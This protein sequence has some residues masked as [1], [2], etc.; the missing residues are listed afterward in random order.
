VAENVKSLDLNTKEKEKQ[1][2]GHI[3][4]IKS[5]GRIIAMIE[6][7]TS[8]EFENHDQYQSL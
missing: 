5:I 1:N 8:G 3:M 2:P 7:G 4:G 6:T